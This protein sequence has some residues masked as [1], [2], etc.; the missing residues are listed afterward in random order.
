MLST[1]QTAENPHE[2]EHELRECVARLAM[3]DGA[4]GAD[5][6]GSQPNIARRLLIA[7]RGV[8]QRLLELHS[9]LEDRSDNRR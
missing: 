4:L 3:I 7:R 2:A 5:R 1:P 6:H 8:H 9:R